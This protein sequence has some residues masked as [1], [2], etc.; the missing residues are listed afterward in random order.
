[1]FWSGHDDNYFVPYHKQTN[2]RIPT[3]E[4]TNEMLEKVY[5]LCGLD[6]QTRLPIANTLVD[7]S[8]LVSLLC[9]LVVFAMR[10]ADGWLAQYL[11]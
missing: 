10:L 11:R 6:K 3:M 8:L 2:K 4:S 5:G 7:T 9:S 1:M